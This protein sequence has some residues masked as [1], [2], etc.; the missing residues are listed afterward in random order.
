MG[1]TSC[2]KRNNNEYINNTRLEKNNSKINLKYLEEKIDA[3]VHNVLD[4]E[5]TIGKKIITFILTEASSGK[6]V[7]FLFRYVSALKI[8]FNFSLAKDVFK[9]NI[10]VL[11][12]LGFNWLGGDS[13]F[14]N[15]TL[16]SVYT[17]KIY[18]D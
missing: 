8:K 2:Y 14:F 1:N 7:V 18:V 10:N 4:D 9:E 6:D 16:I 3:I 12:K 5:V 17:N 15:D 13:I 11:R